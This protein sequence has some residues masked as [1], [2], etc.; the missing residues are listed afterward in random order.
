MYFLLDISVQGSQALIHIIGSMSTSPIY[1]QRSMSNLRQEGLNQHNSEL[2]D[3]KVV[4]LVSNTP[5]KLQEKYHSGKVLNVSHFGFSDS[6]LQLYSLRESF[7][8]IEHFGI[9]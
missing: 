2:H 7:G 8:D 5:R 1:V 9:I 4:G 3:V 6:M